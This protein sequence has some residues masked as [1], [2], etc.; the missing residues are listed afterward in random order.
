MVDATHFAQEPGDDVAEDNGLIGLVVVGRSWDASKVPEVTLPFIQPRILASSVEQ[1]DLGSALDQPPSIKQDH[2][3][4]AHG[5]YGST[6]EGVRWFLWLDLHR[7]RLVGER[8]DEAVSVS[9]FRDSD[10]NLCLDDGVDSAYFVS[11]LPCAL[12][13]QRVANVASWLGHTDRS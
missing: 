6:E 11:D 7:G 12:K 10:R 4:S 8:A 9:V 13:Q 3:F 2:A 5:L 1:D